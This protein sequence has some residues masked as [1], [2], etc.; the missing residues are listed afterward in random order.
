MT[1]ARPQPTVIG[2]E[3]DSIHPWTEHV[4]AA[5]ILSQGVPPETSVAT[6]D[7]LC[8]SARYLGIAGAL[9]GRM[10][11][12]LEWDLAHYHGYDQLPDVVRTPLLEG[13]HW[14]WH[15]AA[16]RLPI[17]GKCALK[18]R[19]DLL[20]GA[21]D[22]DESILEGLVPSE[23]ADVW[24]GDRLAAAGRYEE[25]SAHFQRG[26]SPATFVVPAV[27][28]LAFARWRCGDTLEAAALFDAS[29]HFPDSTTMS[30]RTFEHSATPAVVM[31]YRGDEI[32]SDGHTFTRRSY[33][34]HEEIVTSGTVNTARGLMRMMTPRPLYAWVRDVLF[35]KAI[36]P[37]L[38]RHRHPDR[39]AQ[40]FQEALDGLK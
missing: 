15:Q 2:S 23:I 35:H 5:E 13:N 3:A 8:D 36:V 12:E 1:Q 22:Q 37:L 9:T 21:Q 6:L 34:H 27:V 14:T 7:A 29:V 26:I 28:Q 32:L 39:K 33:V 24:K 40:S 38:K 30:A 4:R 19:L 10:L 20:S 18:V 25:A 16:L 31:F 17:G 11:G